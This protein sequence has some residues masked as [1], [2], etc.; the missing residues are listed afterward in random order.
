MCK[1]LYRAQ[2]PSKVF[3]ELNRAS[4]ILRDVFNDSYTGIHVD[5]LTLYNEVKEY[6]A[7]IAPDKENIV[8]HY[9]KTITS[10]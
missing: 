1:K 8:K 5:D 7:E 3:V 6:V 9:R 2:T 10:S 4:S